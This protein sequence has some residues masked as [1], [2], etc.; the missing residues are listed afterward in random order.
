VGST[1]SR[2][3]ITAIAALALAAGVAH[4]APVTKPLSIPLVADPLAPLGTAVRRDLDL[5]DDGTLDVRIFHI[6]DY[7][8]GIPIGTSDDE[9]FGLNGAQILKV[10]F[11]AAPLKPGQSTDPAGTFVNST[12]IIQSFHPFPGS[13]PFLDPDTAIGVRIPVGGQNYYAWL[14]AQSKDNGGSFSYNTFLLHDYGYETSPNTPVA[15][16]APEPSTFAVVAVAT[17]PLF[18]RRRRP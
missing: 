1:S 11:S 14:G 4:A 18:G 5:N 6:P 8:N 17:A 15:A 2:S 9:V 10:G 7:N 16:L 13:L 12:S 3:F